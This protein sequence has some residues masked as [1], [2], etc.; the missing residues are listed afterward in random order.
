MRALIVSDLHGNWPALRAVLA[1]EPD[2][3]T[4]I[5]L[6]DLVNYGPHPVECVG[7]AQASATWIVQGNHDRA[8]GCNEDPR[9]SAPYREMADVM[10][11]VTGPQLDLAAKNFLAQLPPIATPA[12]D[13]ASLVLCH[14]A[15]SDPLYA[16]VPLEKTPR[17]EDETALARHP[18][19]LLVGHTH[20]GFVR[21]IGETTIVNPGSVGQPKDGDPRAAYAVWDDGVVELRRAAYD[22]RSVVNDL[23]RCAPERIARRLGHLLLTGGG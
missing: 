4:V 8:L 20:R 6:G 12:I 21:R 2:A 14:A 7:W 18:D 3:E 17:W 23:E 5:C 9:C 19:Y 22:I 11:K 13:G 1:A 15:P 16:Y 10:R